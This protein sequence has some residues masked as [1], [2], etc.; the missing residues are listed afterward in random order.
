MGSPQERCNCI[1]RGREISDRAITTGV[2]VYLYRNEG[3][4]K[5]DCYRLL[6]CPGRTRDPRRPVNCSTDRAAYAVKTIQPKETQIRPVHFRDGRRKAPAS[7]GW[8]T[9]L[10]IPVHFRYCHPQL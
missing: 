4:G 3:G 8:I 10:T 5:Q 6:L 9:E 2:S 7:T 1:S